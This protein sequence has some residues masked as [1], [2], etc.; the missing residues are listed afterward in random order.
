VDNQEKKLQNVSEHGTCQTTSED[1]EIADRG[2]VYRTSTYL[3]IVQ[4]CIMHVPAA[5][6]VGSRRCVACDT[7]HRRPRCRGPVNSQFGGYTGSSRPRRRDTA[8]A[9]RDGRIAAES[10][11]HNTSRFTYAPRRL[12]NSDG[13]QSSRSPPNGVRG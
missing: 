11:T 9:R 12:T 8:S 5:T 13:R 2:V 10:R 3:T 7:L 6:A 4:Q 1:D